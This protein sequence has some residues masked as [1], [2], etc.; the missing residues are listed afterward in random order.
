[1]S[2]FYR[3]AFKC[4]ADETTIKYDFDSQEGFTIELEG[5]SAGD[6]PTEDVLRG[7]GDV[8]PVTPDDEL[9]IVTEQKPEEDEFRV[10]ELEFNVNPEDDGDDKPTVVTVTFTLENGTDVI[11]IRTVSLQL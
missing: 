3:A 11:I 8:L 9:V 10:M 2:W 5:P 6:E 7:S 4:P 1:M